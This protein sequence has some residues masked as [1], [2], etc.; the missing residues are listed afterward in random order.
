[1]YTQTL[2]A[3]NGLPGFTPREQALVGL[4]ARYH[5]KGKPDP[6]EYERLLEDGDRQRVE[7][8]SALLRMAEFL[9]RGRGGTVQ[10]IAVRVG[11]EDLALLLLATEQP[12]VE[13]WEAERRAVPL[14]QEAFRRRIT[15]SWSTPE[16]LEP[17]LIGL[18]RS[19]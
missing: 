15:L 1:L 9:E 18:R 12:A 17:G 4:I 14:M 6:G 16:V 5:R 7:L 19:R 11:S 8:L 10:D 13:M 2:I 3:S